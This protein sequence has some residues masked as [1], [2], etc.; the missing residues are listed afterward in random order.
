MSLPVIIIGA[1]GHSKVLIDALQLSCHKIIGIVDTDPDKKGTSILGIPVIGDDEI[2]CSYSPETIQLVNGIGSTAL[3][4]LRQS[5]FETFR[6]KGYMFASVI[7]PSAVIAS[8]V[9]IAEGVQ[10][11]AGA[12]IQPGCFV[13]LNTIINTRASVDHDCSIGEHVHLSP[14]VTL[15]G[16][17]GI[18]DGSHIGTG[19][20]VIQGIGIGSGCLVA[21]GAV[22]VSNI[23]DNATVYGVP[24]KEAKH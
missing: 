15:S 10:I 9:E 13:G 1:G 3:P 14:G 23:N 17:V 5:I 12:V 6:K 21:A 8:C 20:T 18:G 7:H 11:M 16:N 4:L 19:A 2:V 22:V 24:A